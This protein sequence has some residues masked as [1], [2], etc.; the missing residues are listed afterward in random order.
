[1][2]DKKE[3]PYGLCFCGCGEKTELNP[4]TYNKIG[5]KKG[6]P[7]KYIYQ[8]QSRGPN[9]SGANNNN[10]KGGERMVHSGHVM[11]RKPNHPYVTKNKYIKRSRI[12]MEERLGCILPEWIIIHHKNGIR[13]DDRP[14]N[15]HIFNS[16]SEHNTFHQNEIAKKMCGHY[17]WRVCSFCHKYDDIKNMGSSKIKNKSPR[18]HHMECQRLYMR[19]RRNASK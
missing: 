12:V 14:E 7:K 8:H 17:E 15:L 6:E 3:I 5:V 18:Y 19:K 11:V 4:R 2:G 9:N 13:H 16:H 1:M 10:W